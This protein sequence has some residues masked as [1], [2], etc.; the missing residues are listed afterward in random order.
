MHIYQLFIR[1]GKAI[2]NINKRTILNEVGGYIVNRKFKISGINDGKILEDM[3]NN[4][5][6]KK[7]VY[8]SIIQ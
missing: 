1:Y 4:L 7:N 3:Y 2:S 5:A 8:K 6:K